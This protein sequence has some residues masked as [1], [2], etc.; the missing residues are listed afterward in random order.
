MSPFPGSTSELSPSVGPKVCVDD[1]NTLD[2]G[3]S[4]GLLCNIDADCVGAEAVNMFRPVGIPTRYPIVCR[5]NYVAVS[6]DPFKPGRLVVK[7]DVKG[8]ANTNWLSLTGSLFIYDGDSCEAPGSPYMLVAGFTPDTCVDPLTDAELAT[9]NYYGTPHSPAPGAYICTKSSEKGIWRHAQTFSHTDAGTNNG[10]AAEEYQTDIGRTHQQ[11]YGKPVVMHRGIG[12][13]TEKLACGIL[14]APD[15]Y[16]ARDRPLG[17]PG[18]GMTGDWTACSQ[19]LAGCGKS[20]EA[21]TLPLAELALIDAVV[22][23]DPT[24][25]FQKLRRGADPEARRA[26]K[27]SLLMAAFHGRTHLVPMLLEEGGADLAAVQEPEGRGVVTQAI[28]NNHD[29]TVALLLDRGAQ[30]EQRDHS[31]STPLHHAAEAGHTRSANLLLARGASVAARDEFGRTPLMRAVIERRTETVRAL[32]G[33]PAGGPDLEARSAKNAPRAGYT[34]LMY[35]VTNDDAPTLA[36]LVNAGASVEA[37]DGDTNTPLIA[38]S[39]EGFA[40]VARD[41]LAAGARVDAKNN[42]GCAGLWTA[43]QDPKHWPEADTPDGARADPSATRVGSQPA[44]DPVRGAKG[45]CEGATAL[46]Y[47][48]DAATARVLMDHGAG[49]QA[50]DDSRL[51]HEA[52]QGRPETWAY[53]WHGE[54]LATTDALWAPNSGREKSITFEKPAGWE[55]SVMYVRDNAG[56]DHEFTSGGLPRGVEWPNLAPEA[57]KTTTYQGQTIAGVPEGESGMCAQGL[58]Y[59]AKTNECIAYSPVVTQKPV[60]QHITMSSEPGSAAFVLRHDNLPDGRAAVGNPR[61][62]AERDERD[63]RQRGDAEGVLAQLDAEDAQGESG[64][65]RFLNKHELGQLVDKMLGEGFRSVADLLLINSKQDLN[66]IGVQRGT[67]EWTRLH[68]AIATLKVGRFKDF[69]NKTYV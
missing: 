64:L 51:R 41:L 10:M 54:A 16:Q 18:G 27:T 24:H 12:S 6:E 26:G 42:H 63:E 53:N 13:G 57:T 56:K 68:R 35:A 19:T 32:L 5:E 45:R 17:G 40:G 67:P 59:N 58:Y 61:Q 62:R 43:D 21:G 34:A 55:S 9:V 7:V 48:Q 69:T 39:R 15:G 29:K 52:F 30:I 3:R 66:P 46:F 38:A 50:A 20:G 60:V 14:K 37:R 8:E 65:R 1:A 2:D 33:G 11:I 23:G 36:A 28:L 49:T 22:M 47:A 4:N 44:P 25:T 31:G